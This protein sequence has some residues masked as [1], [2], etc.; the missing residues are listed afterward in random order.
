MAAIA[1]FG[2]FG[3]GAY[4]Q[5]TNSTVLQDPLYIGLSF[6]A[7]LPVLAVLGLC[8]DLVRR[9]SFKLTSPVLFSLVS[10]L[11]LLLGVAAGAV[12]SIHAIKAGPVADLGITHAVVY[13]GLIAALG[14]FHHWAT[15]IVGRPLSEALGLLAPLLLLVGA[16]AF[17][18]PD[19]ISGWTGSDTAKSVGT[20]GLN[21]VMVIGFGIALIGVTVAVLNLVGG[22]RKATDVPADPWGGQTLEWATASPPAFDNFE[23]LPVVH[24]PEPLLDQ[25]EETS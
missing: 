19:L 12:N 10:L 7:V 16:A 18:I 14:A 3:F 1:A 21:T 25:T 24:S 23:A 22:L 9:G 20:Q 4:L 11:V 5:S 8:G 2:I 17:V 13:A 15:K 6:L